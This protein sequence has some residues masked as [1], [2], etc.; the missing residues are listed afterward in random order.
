MS[1]GPF[2]TVEI[3]TD[4]AK[5]VEVRTWGFSSAGEV[6]VCPDLP[7]STR[8]AIVEL[9]SRGAKHVYAMASPEDHPLFGRRWVW[10]LSW[11]EVP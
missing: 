6:A 11:V 5:P 10:S 9:L 4:N 3:K 1:G 7:R 2:H 8:C